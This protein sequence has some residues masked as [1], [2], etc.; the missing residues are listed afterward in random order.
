MADA[1][2]PVEDF[3]NSLGKLEQLGHVR[4]RRAQLRKTVD[5]T[6]PNVDGLAS[7]R[8]YIHLGVQTLSAKESKLPLKLVNIQVF[9][10]RDNIK[11]AFGLVFAISNL[12]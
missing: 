2:P 10:T 1:K 12:I 8:I 11:F 9:T 4:K 3:H 6:L 7:K 5:L